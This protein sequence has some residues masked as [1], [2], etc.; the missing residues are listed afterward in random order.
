MAGVLNRHAQHPS[1]GEFLVGHFCQER[2]LS[3][4]LNQTENFELHAH[5]TFVLAGKFSVNSWVRS[6]TGKVTVGQAVHPIVLVEQDL[7]TFTEEAGTRDFTKEEIEGFFSAIV[8]EFDKT[9]RLYYPSG[10]QT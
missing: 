8:P 1:P 6:K 9:L 10:S 7:N 5:K 3:G 4:P 2:W